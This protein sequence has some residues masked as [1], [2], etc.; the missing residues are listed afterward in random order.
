MSRGGTKNLG[1]KNVRLSY[2]G[3]V[4]A[5]AYVLAEVSTRHKDW[6]DMFVNVENVLLFLPDYKGR[7]ENTDTPRGEFQWYAFHG[8]TQAPLIAR[9][10]LCLCQSGHYESAGA[11][12]RSLIEGFVQLRYFHAHPE[13]LA[14]HIS[15]KSRSGKVSFTTMMEAFS[16]GFYDENYRYL[17]DLTHS[18]IPALLHIDQ[19]APG[20]PVLVGVEYNANYVTYYLNVMLPILLGFLRFFPIFFPESTLQSDAQAFSEYKQADKS[21]VEDI[22][23]HKQAFPKSL[24]WYQ[25]AEPLFLP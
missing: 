11:I 9:A 5:E 25:K 7:T 21:L 24:H 1:V 14:K 8:L 6:L 23:R 4:K 13:E 22:Q 12:I 10:A 16:P 15:A 3:L 17:C 18:K 2:E 19:N 20:N